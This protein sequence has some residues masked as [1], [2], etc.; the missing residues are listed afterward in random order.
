MEESRAFR[1]VQENANW[2]FPFD[3]YCA[4]VDR[5][6][7]IEL[8]DEG[9]LHSLEGKAM[10]FRDG[11]GLWYINGV[12]VNEQIVMKPETLTFEQIRD[13]D[14][15]EIKRIMIEQHGWDKY[16]E[17]VP[18]EVV[19]VSASDKFHEALI[20]LEDML[21]LLCSC[22]STGRVYALEVDP[23]ISSVKEAR[24]WLCPFDGEIIANT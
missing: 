7:R 1:K 12:E 19:E 14:N 11:F 9:R 2:W 8:N 21:V 18:H 22:P 4:V 13:E 23:S 10:E 17:S 24:G 3:T 5:P 16:L 6:L 20:K 15:A